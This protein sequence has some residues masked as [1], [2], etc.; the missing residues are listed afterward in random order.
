MVLAMAGVA[1]VFLSQHERREKS[2]IQMVDQD[3]AGGNASM[4]DIAQDKGN[5]AA[6]TAGHHFKRRDRRLT[7]TDLLGRMMT[8][9]TR[10]EGTGFL[11]LHQIPDAILAA[12]DSDFRELVPKWIADQTEPHDVQVCDCCGDGEEWYGEPGQHY[13]ADDPPGQSGPYASNGGLCQCH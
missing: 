8:T 2:A 1:V 11:N 5:V 3:R 4:G 13:G 7:L 10:C 12:M 6:A 9:C